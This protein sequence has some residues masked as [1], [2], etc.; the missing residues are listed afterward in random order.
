MR[1][2]REDERDECESTMHFVKYV[3]SNRWATGADIME[4]MLKVSSLGD[5]YVLTEIISEQELSEIMEIDDMRE[6]LH[7]LKSYL[8]RAEKSN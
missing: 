8:N 7:K 4:A 2:L 3:L 5:K 1:P 6:L